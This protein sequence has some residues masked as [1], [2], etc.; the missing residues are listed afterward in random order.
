MAILDGSLLGVG[1]ARN[2]A[3]CGLGAKF[4]AGEKCCCSAENGFLV[5]GS[6]SADREVVSS[7]D[8]RVG[9]RNT[10]E[11]V[12]I[13][14]EDFARVWLGT[15]TAADTELADG[16][17]RCREAVRGGLDRSCLTGSELWVLLDCRVEYDLCRPPVVG[18]P[19]LARAEGG[20]IE[21]LLTT[22]LAALGGPVDV[23]VIFRVGGLIGSRLGD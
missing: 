4:L 14:E 18:L 3:G 23:D 19:I 1:G 13:M 17:R 22:L 8:P 11:A 7:V 12:E 5:W 20:R 21:A 10:G 9:G 6:G 15:R 2:D 16:L